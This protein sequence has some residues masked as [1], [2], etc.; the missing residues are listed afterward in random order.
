MA[1]EVWKRRKWIGYVWARLS[2]G[3]A[4]VLRCLPSSRDFASPKGNKLP[5]MRRV[6]RVSEASVIPPSEERLPCPL[7]NPIRRYLIFTHTPLEIGW[8]ISSR[9]PMKVTHS[10]LPAALYSPNDYRI[11]WYHNR[12][13][14]TQVTVRTNYVKFHDSIVACIDKDCNSKKLSENDIENGKSKIY[15]SLHYTT[16]YHQID[17]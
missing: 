14:T 6:I 17:N 10:E 3:R 12:P 16:N 5:W 15:I 7:A 8:T 13:M 2:W 9:C 4:F 1:S 11:R